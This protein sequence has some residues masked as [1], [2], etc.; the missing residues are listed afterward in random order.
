MWRG[1]CRRGWTRLWRRR[2][3]GGFEGATADALREVVSGR[4]K[5][6]VFNVAR[7]FSLAGEA[8]AEYR[9]ALMGAQQS[10]MQAFQATRGVA[11]GDAKLAGSRQRVADQQSAVADAA[12]V[13]ERA[14]ADAAAMVS[15]PIKVPSLFDRIWKGIEKGL[16]WAAIVLAAL[17]AFGGGP[18]GMMALEAG[19]ASFAMTAVDVAR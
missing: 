3:R 4:L 8:V 5:T 2:R 11:A 19:A 18:L 17:A 13:M 7:S 10:V 12:A 9:L 15:Q 14:L 6:F 16:F 1:R